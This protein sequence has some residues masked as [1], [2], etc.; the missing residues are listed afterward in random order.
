[1]ARAEQVGVVRNASDAVMDAVSHRSFAAGQA[2]MERDRPNASVEVFAPARL[3]LGFLDLDGGLGRRFG[4]LGVAID[5]FETRLR[6]TAATAAG[7]SG[8]AAPR[9][10]DYLDRAAAALGVPRGVHI[11][12]SRGTPEHV[13]LGSGTQLG[14]AVA[15]ATYL[16]DPHKLVPGTKMIFPGLKKEDD[17]QNVIAYLETPK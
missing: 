8:P 17:R 4:G 9:A 13:G 3:H 7:A 15:A 10:L 2:T 11:A 6:M 5:G 14:L 12:I 16:V 1:V